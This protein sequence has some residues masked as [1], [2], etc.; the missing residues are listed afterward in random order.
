M[1]EEPR[2]V[3]DPGA[4]REGLLKAPLVVAVWGHGVITK[5]VSAGSVAER[6]CSEPETFLWTVR[7]DEISFVRRE[8]LAALRE[9]LK[10]AGIV[11]LY[12]ECL[13]DAEGETTAGVAERFSSE[14]TGW[15][16]VL[17]PS[18]EGSPL[19][20]LVARRLAL[21]VLG[22]LMLLLAVNFAVAS[23]VAD[24][25]R[26]ANATLAALRKT[27]SAGAAAD[28]RRQAAVEEFSRGAGLHAAR[29]SDV[30]G[31]AVPRGVTLH[32]LAIVPVTK[33]PEKGKPLQRR[34]NAVV[35]GG[36]TPDSEE[37]T[38][39]ADALSGLEIGSV[40]LTSVEQAEERAVFTFRIEI[41]L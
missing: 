26:E 6:V 30:I 12:I 1:R 15:K 25:F 28:E 14:H 21:P 19:A 22:V 23:R 8:R 9:R 27:S 31:A 10:R 20:S 36:E 13:P 40:R 32:E 39:F 34:E 17:T 4:E 16:R 2:P 5:A 3:A 18:A 7:G 11:P 29:L 41:A 35:I 37:I 38:G 24:D 33:A